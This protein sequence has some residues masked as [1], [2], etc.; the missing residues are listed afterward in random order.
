MP[1]R[2]MSTRSSRAPS[3]FPSPWR[4]PRLQIAPEYPRPEPIISGRRSHHS[5]RRSTSCISIGRKG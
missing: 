1:S 3:R 2:S 5:G 4:G